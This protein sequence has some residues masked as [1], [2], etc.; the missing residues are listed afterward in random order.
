MA[1]AGKMQCTRRTG[2]AFALLVCAALP[3]TASDFLVTMKELARNPVAFVG[4]HVVL[5]DCFMIG[6]NNLSGAQC[7]VN[8]IDAATL[9][10]VDSDT[11]SAQARRLIDECNTAI[12]E[13]MCVIKVTGDVTTN[14]RGQ[15]LI[16]NAIVEIVT[17]PSQ[18]I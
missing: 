4:Q 18:A 9:V 14:R 6:A 2:V 7:S 15:A 17:R 3:A 5:S 11:W 13:Q 16:L 1:G 12:I 10:Y 8:P